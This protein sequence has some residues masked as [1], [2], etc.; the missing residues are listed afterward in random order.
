M[1]QGRHKAGHAAGHRRASTGVRKAPPGAR[2]APPEARR[3]SPVRV[4]G[5]KVTGR[6]LAHGDGRPA[7]LTA[8]G[9]GEKLFALLPLTVLS[10]ASVVGLAANGDGDPTASPSPVDRATT[11]G[12]VGHQAAL[13]QAPEGGPPT[14]ARSSIAATQAPAATP[15]DTS[16]EVVD[17][18]RDPVDA[19][20]APSPRPEPSKGPTGSPAEADPPPTAAPTASPTSE[21]DATNDNLLTKAEAT[22]QCLQSGI[23]TLDVVALTACVRELLG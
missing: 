15:E 21:P 19:P 18:E 12:P 1:G 16:P 2:K 7:V 11:S 8:L 17:E 4:G 13:R 3:A 20:T 23:S 6:R 10:V 9:S 14:A 5:A 22:A